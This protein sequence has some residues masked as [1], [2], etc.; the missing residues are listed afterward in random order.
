MKGCEFVF[1]YSHLLY[2]KYHKRNLNHGGL[3][4]DSP[5]WIKNKQAAI[6]SANKK[7]NKCF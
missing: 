3:Y 4:V 1:D 7:D 5:D 6:N 2:Y